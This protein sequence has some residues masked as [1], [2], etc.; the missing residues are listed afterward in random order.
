[1][2]RRRSAVSPASPTT[3]I[4]VLLGIF[5]ACF[6]LSCARIEEIGEIE[7]PVTPVLTVENNWAVIVSSHLRLRDAPSTDSAAIATLWKG[8]VLEILSKTNLLE[9][10]DDLAGFWYRIS[11]D[12]LN[13]WVFG[14]YLLLYDSQAMAER[15]ASELKR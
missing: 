4:A 8:S 3:I 11:Y 10:V 9:M 15:S 1:M 14:P 6:D 13:G 12:G 2:R 7:L 5:V